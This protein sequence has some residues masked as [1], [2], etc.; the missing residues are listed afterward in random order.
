M[1]LLIADDQTSLHTFLNKM[2]D[3]TSLG[4]KEIQHA[5]DGR[6]TL[7]LIKA[8]S[9]DIVILDIQMPFMSGIE[10]LQ[11]LDG[12]THKPKTIIVSA[13]DEF[14][15][16]CEALRLEVYQYLL[17]PVDVVL[18]TRT[19]KE[20]VASIQEEQRMKFTHLLTQFVH[21]RSLDKENLDNAQRAFRIMELKQY[22]ML[23]IVG[24]SLSESS[25]TQ[26][27]SAADSALIPIIT[28]TNHDT[29][30]CFLGIS[31]AMQES[32]LIE[33]CQEMSQALGND[34]SKPAVIIGVSS[35]HTGCDAE[36]LPELL[37]QSEKA[38]ML[39]FYTFETV[40]G[41]T[42]EAFNEE[43]R[44]Q[45]FQSYE[46]A[47]RELVTYDFRIEAAQQV[48]ADMFKHIRSSRIPPEDV[49]SLVL[50]FQYIIAQSISPSSRLR[51]NLENVTLQELKKHRNLQQLEHM[52]MS[53]IDNLAQALEGTDPAKDVVQRV[54]HHI[55]LHY[56]EDLSL[57]VIAD[58]F[59]IDKFQ[60]SRLFKQELGVNY[61]NYVIQVRMEKA[62]ELLLRT[63][64][65]NSS[66]ASAT[67][68]VD[69][70]H[71]SRTFKKYY[72]MSPKQYRNMHGNATE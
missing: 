68:F 31:S 71:F 34:S 17:K 62:A 50:H 72:D 58:R 45:D 49:Y 41:Y 19:I 67:G 48:I 1:K 44:M 16:A 21:T 57:Q 4:I 13:H 11:E 52:F 14:T 15:Y 32:R 43:W 7:Q 10:T 37:I 23:H 8:F 5:Y 40:N 51:I 36:R 39:S 69:E 33:L 35:I 66:I 70:S 60:L 54:K 25:I 12:S 9:P 55:D 20:L 24:E 2:M 18:L 27:L 26:C 64:E 42:E 61:W 59:G 53:L 22:A 63:E 3:W 28:Q 6:E 29:Y 38:S 46:Q 47:F 30:S 56:G 65:K